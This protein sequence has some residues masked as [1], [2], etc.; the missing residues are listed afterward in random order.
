[1]R[2]HLSRPVRSHWDDYLIRQRGAAQRATEPEAVSTEASISEDSPTDVTSSEIEESSSES[3]RLVTPMVRF[4]DS[5]SEDT[6]SQS[7]DSPMPDVPVEADNP[8]SEESE[9]LDS[10]SDPDNTLATID[11]NAGLAL[12]LF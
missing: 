10:W 1:M 8:P 4:L 12:R 6:S 2:W 11:R 9:S 7:A 3:L 5:S